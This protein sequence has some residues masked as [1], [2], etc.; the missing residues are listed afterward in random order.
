MRLQQLDIWTFFWINYKTRFYKSYHRINDFIKLIPE[1]ILW[2]NSW[3]HGKAM[4]INW[5][6]L[7]FSK[8]FWIMERTCSNQLCNVPFNFDTSLRRVIFVNISKAW[9]PIFHTSNFFPF[10]SGNLWKMLCS[11]LRLHTQLNW[12]HALCSTFWTWPRRHCNQLWNM[13]FLDFNFLQKQWTAYWICLHQSRENQFDGCFLCC[14][15]PQV[16]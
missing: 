8:F 16:S 14:F 7:F 6:N 3:E 10:T 2:F 1:S 9:V 15:W 5:A 11:V 12:K 4:H 13:L